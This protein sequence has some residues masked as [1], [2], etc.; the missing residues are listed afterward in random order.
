[1][2]E[3]ATSPT[4][5]SPVV[6][7][8]DEE[9]KQIGVRVLLVIGVVL[10]VLMVVFGQATA[11]GYDQF[12][13]YHRATLEDPQHPPRWDTEALDVE[14]CVDDVLTWV[15]SC[16]GVSSWCEGSLPDVMNMCLDTQDRTAYCDGV[17][18]AVLSTRFG[19]EL[20]SARY[21]KIEG[22]YARRYAKKH[23]SILYRVIAGRC[24][25]SR[26]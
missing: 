23:C 13:S 18:D 20:C 11:T 16:P 14:A 25:N 22:H 21:D 17:G 2:S 7:P 10:A 5:P 3:T 26:F 1:M 12:E 4:P 9:R 19:F 15:E 6:G 24:S 8:S